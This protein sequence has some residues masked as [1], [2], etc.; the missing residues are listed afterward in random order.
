[1]PTVSH[2]WK[3]SDADQE[4]GTWPVM[5]TSG[6]ESIR[7]SVQ[8]RHGI[9]GARARGDQHH[10][11]LAGRA[12]IAFGGV[13]G[14]LLVADQNVLNVLLLEQLVIDRQHRTAGIA[15]DV[16]DP[17]VLQRLDDH[18][19][20]GH[21]AAAAFVVSVAHHRCFPSFPAPGLRVISVRIN[22]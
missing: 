15:E 14:T 3:A 2:S 17:V 5:Q 9:G 13:A 7:A 20:P 4:V 1:M 8:R 12:G 10:A 11:G 19:G 22:Q 21:F 16:L 6:I 18:L